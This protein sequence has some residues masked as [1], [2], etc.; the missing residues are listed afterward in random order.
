MQPGWIQV[1]LPSRPNQSTGW[2]YLGGG[3]LQNAYSTYQVQIEL[4]A[5]RLTVFKA[6]RQVGSW[7]VAVGAPSTPTPTGRTY[8]LA[9]MSPPRPTYSSLFL[10]LGT[11]SK[12][13]D[14]FAGGSGTIALHGWPDK[15][16]FGHAVSHG[17]V[18]VPDA[19]LRMLSR[20]PLG[21]TVTITA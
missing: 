13:L 9:S 16:V 20:I 19:A 12:S 2:I 3:G 10:P 21:T 11:H 7:T 18:R 1:L 15:T 14:T 17:C 8:L 4:A 5:H 6:G